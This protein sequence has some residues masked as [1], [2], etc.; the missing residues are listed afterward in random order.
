MQQVI[1]R[2]NVHSK[3]LDKMDQPSLELQVRYKK[4]IGKHIYNETAVQKTTFNFSIVT[5]FINIFAGFSVP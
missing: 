5:P 4:Y 3:N 2:Q 1:E